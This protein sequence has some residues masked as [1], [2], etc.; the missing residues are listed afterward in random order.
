[1]GIVDPNNVLDKKDGLRMRP[2]KHFLKTIN[3]LDKKIVKLE[4]ILGPM[5][6]SDDNKTDIT[7]MLKE[8]RKVRGNYP[9][10]LLRIAEI[11]KQDKIAK[12]TME[13]YTRIPIATLTYLG[14]VTKQK[15]DSLYPKSRNMEVMYFTKLGESDL[16][17]YNSLIDIR[18]KDYMSLSDKEKQSIVKVSFFQQLKRSGILEDY[19]FGDYEIDSE[20]LENK[21]G[22]NPSFL[23]SPYQMLNHFEVNKLLEIEVKDSNEY[24]PLTKKTLMGNKDNITDFISNNVTDIKLQSMFNTISE[25]DKETK[26]YKEI[27]SNKDVPIKELID[28]LVEKYKT[29]NQNVFYPLVGD[30]FSILGFN[31]T[32]SRAGTNYERYDAIIISEN[33]IPIEIKS[34]GEELNI[35]VKAI[36]QALENKVI[37]LSRENHPTSFDTTSLAV[38]FYLP[39]DRAEVMTLVD[40]IKNTFDIN[41]GVIDFPTLLEIVINKVLYDRTFTSSEIESLKGMI[42]VEYDEN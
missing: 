16:E 7:L 30:L 11:S 32:V 28:L 42:N 21:F 20:I 29:A 23:F 5:R 9:S 3:A 25:S 26:I 36:R 34:P 41:I 2:F 33:S 15:G 19:P 14:W 4:L 35:S 10:L 22:K 31:C 27:I 13:N 24:S 38:G 37:L 39:N 8:I 17:F 18:L 6:Y 12:T 1:M 40:D